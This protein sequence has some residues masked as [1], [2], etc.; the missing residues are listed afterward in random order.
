VTRRRNSGTL[1]PGQL[2][3]NRPLSTCGR[4]PYGNSYVLVIEVKNKVVLQLSAKRKVV[5]SQWKGKTLVSMREYYEKDGKVLPTSK[6]LVLFQL[7]LVICCIYLSCP[8]LVCA[9][10]HVN[11]CG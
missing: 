5:V 4:C 11:P 7:H 8:D 1:A 6:G 9:C 3:S 10:T 2:F